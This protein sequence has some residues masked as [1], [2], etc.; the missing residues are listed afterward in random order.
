MICLAVVLALLCSAVF[1]VRAVHHDCTGADCRVCAQMQ[2]CARQLYR[3]CLL[4]GAALAVPLARL[5][6][7][8]TAGRTR[9]ALC[10][11]PILL[12]VKLSC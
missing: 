6:G 10:G 11:T 7:A 1:L 2:L 9:R 12:R 4:T 5:F 3:M 8:H